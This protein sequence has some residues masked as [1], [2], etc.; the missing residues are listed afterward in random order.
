M[1]DT[2]TSS[3]FQPG[4]SVYFSCTMFCDDEADSAVG[5]CG[6]GP[7]GLSGT[8]GNVTATRGPL[9][10]IRTLGALWYLVITANDSVV[11]TVAGV[12]VAP[13]RRDELRSKKMA[14]L[15]V[16]H[17]SWHTDPNQ[18]DECRAAIFTNTDPRNATLFQQNAVSV[19]IGFDETTASVFYSLSGTTSTS[20]S[21]MRVGEFLEDVLFDPLPPLTLPPKSSISNTTDTKSTISTTSTTTTV[22]NDTLAR[23]SN[24]V[25]QET[26]TSPVSGLGTEAIIGIAAGA[27]AVF[28]LLAVA[29]T[30]WIIRRRR[31][32]DNDGVTMAQGPEGEMQSAIFDD[33]E[34][35][36]AVFEPE[37]RQIDGLSLSANANAN[38]GSSEY[39]VVAVDSSYAAPPPD[40][41]YGAPMPEQ[42][43][44]NYDNWDTP[45]SVDYTN[46]SAGTR[47]KV[48]ALAPTAG[49]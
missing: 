4:N 27:A 23:V 22:A 16:V 24:M 3:L 42:Q 32:N 38:V 31:S 12:E 17:C 45:L 25:S 1:N 49:F 48:Y 44:S 14:V 34:L 11:E 21:E 37:Y 26:D 29:I 43:T 40:S 39:G 9:V 10:S 8:R 15:A 5:G 47:Q 41:I 30:C 28:V 18:L 13:S 20:I 19:K 35:Q 6:V 46:T 7:A 2:E 36:S 33:R